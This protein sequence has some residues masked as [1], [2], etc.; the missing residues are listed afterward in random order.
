[1]VLYNTKNFNINMINKNITDIKILLHMNNTNIS[2]TAPINYMDVL[3]VYYSTSFLAKVAT[4]LNRI[5]DAKF[6]TTSVLN[7]KDCFSLANEA[8]IFRIWISCNVK[9]NG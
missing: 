1:M 6:E 9:S 3:F 8:L 2:K 4:Y 5:H 7:V